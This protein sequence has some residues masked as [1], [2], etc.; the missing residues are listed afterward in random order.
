MSGE[1]PATS[2]TGD[3]G[4]RAQ[5]L[6]IWGSPFASMDQQTGELVRHFNGGITRNYGHAGP[7]FVRYL[8]NHREEWPQWRADYARHVQIFEDW[9]GNNVI[10]GRMAVHLAVIAK[11]A[12]VAQ[13]A[14]NL[15]WRFTNPILSTWSDLIRE[16]EQA[17]RATAAL[18]YVKGWAS[19]HQSEFFGRARDG[20]P[21]HQGWAGRW[22]RVRPNCRGNEEEHQQDTW[23][24][25]GFLLYRLDEILRAGGYEPDS[26]R[27]T[28]D[29]RGWLVQSTECNGTVRRQIRQRIGGEL[30]WL[31]AIRRE[32]IDLADGA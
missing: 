31:V 13:S 6:E 8:I 23:N 25:I 15:P 12:R 16:T 30:V 21:P 18:R 10:A 27:R 29:E 28:W 19:A 9:A 7:R 17:D 1:Q 26:V 20:H 32:A 14:L 3:G 4:T 2:F 11:T 24:W 5:V 22:D